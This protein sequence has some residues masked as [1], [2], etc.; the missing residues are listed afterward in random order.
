LL[1]F[2]EAKLSN[3]AEH[4]RNSIQHIVSGR[5]Q[6]VVLMIDNADQRNL[7]VQQEAFV[8]SQNFAQQW[9]AAVFISVR[10][11]T[12]HQSK[13]AGAF[14]AYPQKIFSISPPRA[15]LVIE[16]RLSFALDMAEGR[17]PVERLQGVK[18]NFESLALFLKALLYSLEHN[19]ELV[20]LLTNITGGNIRQ[21]ID[22]VTKFIGSPNVDAHKIINIMS[23]KGRYT[24]AA[25]EFAKSALLGEYAHYDPVSSLAMNIFD[26]RYPDE[27]EHFLVPIVIAYL[28]YD[29]PHRDREGF[30]LSGNIIAEMQNW[31]FTSQQV[32]SVLR[33]TTNKR[34]IETTERITFEEDITGLIGDMPAA[35]RIT[36][37]GAYHLDRWAATFAY[38]DAMAFDTPI[39]DSN[40]KDQLVRDVESIDIQDR[41]QRSM[42]FRNY[43]SNVWN[44]SGLTPQYFDWEAMVSIGNSS[45]QIVSNVIHR[46]PVKEKRKK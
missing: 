25:H 8:I 18:L 46:Q 1:E 24:V 30:V 35:F 43:L 40:T 38:L 39:F 23:E 17:L 45:F 21:V 36:T 11:Q 31:G 27:R 4:L 29:G 16:K 3:K 2:L 13:Q 7:D 41:F 28:K 12:F 9:K 6:Q 19:L 37:I 10:P 33:R 15:D 42:I 34:L 44:K 26:V 14:S 22:L 32:E 5:R 20:E